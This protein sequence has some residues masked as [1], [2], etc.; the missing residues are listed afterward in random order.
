MKDAEFF[1]YFILKRFLQCVCFLC[2]DKISNH[3]KTC[4][5]GVDD[6]PESAKETSE[7]P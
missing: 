5:T 3:L 1:L 6:E 2:D 7:I 4:R